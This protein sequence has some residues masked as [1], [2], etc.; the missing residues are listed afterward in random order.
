MYAANTTL[1]RKATFLCCLSDTVRAG[2]D[3]FIGYVMEWLYT[4]RALW[5]LPTFPADPFPVPTFS[6]A[7]DAFHKALC[8]LACTV[9]HIIPVT[10]S[11]TSLKAVTGCGHGDSCAAN[12]LCD[13]GDILL[14]PLDI[15]V[16]LLSMIRALVLGETPDV[17][18]LGSACSTTNVGGCVVSVLVY[19]VT[20]GILTATLL[21]RDVAAF[22]DCVLCAL[23]QFIDPDATCVPAF[24]GAVD[25]LMDLINGLVTLFLTAILNFI[26][27]IIKVVIYF[28]TGQFDQL[29]AAFLDEVLGSI[30]TFFSRLGDLIWAAIIRIPGIG[31][32]IEAILT[33]VRESCGVLDDIVRAFGGSGIDC[34]GIKRQASGWLTVWPNVTVVWGGGASGA[35]ALAC[36]AA[37]ITALNGTVATALT[38]E[39][40]REAMYCLAAYLWVGDAA[41]PAA[42]TADR[43]YNTECDLLMPALYTSQAWADM[44]GPMRARALPCVEARLVTERIRL[45]DNAPWVPHDMLSNIW[46]IPQLL[47]DAWLAYDV[48]GQYK[49]DRSVPIATLMS[50]G[51]R[52]SWAG[53]GYAVAHLEALGNLTSPTE[54]DVYTALDED[55]TDLGLAPEQYVLR[56]VQLRTEQRGRAYSV[57]RVAGLFNAVI[58]PL[59]NGSRDGSQTSLA[60]Q[61][62]AGFMDDLDLHAD[63]ADLSITLST[64]MMTRLLAADDPR[65]LAQT[66]R[67]FVGVFTRDLPAA[68][69]RIGRAFIAAAPDLKRSFTTTLSLPS[70]LWRAS[71]ALLSMTGDWLR[72]GLVTS[73]AWLREPAVQDWLAAHAS[74]VPPNSTVTAGLW[75]ATPDSS[76]G[77]AA[78]GS[79]LINALGRLFAARAPMVHMG[80]VMATVTSTTTTAAAVRRARLARLVAT[81]TLAASAA[82]TA[83]VRGRDPTMT[84]LVVDASTALPCKTN[85]DL[86]ATCLYLDQALGAAAH[87]FFTMVNYLG[88]TNATLEPTLAHSRAQYDFLANYSRN[89]NATVILGDSPDL[90][91]RWPWRDYNN[92]RI[93]GDPTPNKLRF[94]DVEQLWDDTWALVSDV[95]NPDNVD[96][97]T[98]ISSGSV[99]MQALKAASAPSAADATAGRTLTA[100][101]AEFLAALLNTMPD[102]WRAAPGTA[103]RVVSQAVATLGD[104]AVA[105]ATFIFTSGFQCTYNVELDGS[106]KRFAIGEIVF[107]TLLVGLVA[108][109]VLRAVITGDLILAAAG[110][111]LFGTAFLFLTVWLAYD[112]SVLCFPALPAPLADDL[113]YFIAFTAAPKCSV[114][115]GLFNE[116]NYTSATCYAC[117]GY[118]L[119]TDHQLWTIPD[120]TK[121]RADGGV[122][123]FSDVTYNIIF[124]LRREWPDA[125]VWLT[126]EGQQVPLLGAILR[127]PW[128]QTRLHAYDDYD[129]ATV[130]VVHYS[131]YALGNYVVT[132]LINL[133]IFVGIPLMLLWLLWPLI[134]WVVGMIMA[135]ALV[136]ASAA[137]VALNALYGL[138]E[139]AFVESNAST[140]K[141]EEEIKTPEATPAQREDMAAAQRAETASLLGIHVT[142]RGSSGSW[143]S[144]HSDTRADDT[145][146]PLEEY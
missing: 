83:I 120:Y 115:G 26:V 108:T 140:V 117:A 21:V 4:I 62:A 126:G 12:A 82:Q 133:V 138:T 106:H 72:G 41:T 53:R 54:T 84:R 67:G 92:F 124:T 56:A 87:A 66:M 6:D 69:V 113:M 93:L 112:W 76:T 23:T 135:L 28:V 44:D 132:W 11:C 64:G 39:E 71:V 118:E 30:G 95:F 61:V 81:A 20:K 144:S 13:A 105:W 146:I 123:G 102:T 17:N 68:S 109:L 99:L 89:P 136:G 128:V 101:S 45:T 103:K 86:C 40:K 125:L 70:Q 131:Q 22:L 65:E 141:G 134:T 57:E 88:S 116:E 9:T 80:A 104:A 77:L 114:L 27:G 73:G 91:A 143:I 35:A 31:K 96:D 48:W 42:D 8:K 50:A 75:Q 16:D 58:R 85:E 15:L 142:M 145:V 36:P 52:A 32:L 46:R 24:Y 47:D 98:S 19:I 122:F 34:S 43:A 49:S 94:H 127:L 90:P 18:V 119:G 1:Y 38:S 110:G 7:R 139:I 74:M 37:R 10:F 121:A 137:L 111:L 33:I 59:A 51:Y 5:A 130:T 63:A 60:A 14:L 97:A 100:Y 55:A 107:I 25:F 3:V 78:A 2:N 79:A 129:P 29:I